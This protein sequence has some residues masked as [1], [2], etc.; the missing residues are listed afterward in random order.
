[1]NTLISRLTNHIPPAQFLRYL[2]VGVWNTV[3]GYAVYAL[4]VWILT[5]RIPYAYSAAQV[6]SFFINSTMAYFGYKLFVFKT[7]GNYLKE[8]SKCLA[9]YGSKEIPAFLLL[10]VFVGFLH[11]ALH[12]HRSAPYIAGAV[13]T[14][15][16]TIYT[17]LGNKTFS[18][19]ASNSS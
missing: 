14:G 2:L 16:G 13:I 6:L 9:V 1:M 4:F 11:A 12:L 5:P 18:F 8:W 17:F 19:R 3:V 7:E 15:F 10:P